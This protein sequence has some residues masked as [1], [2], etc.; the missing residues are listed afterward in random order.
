MEDQI[1]SVSAASSSEDIVSHN[2][3]A[4]TVSTSTAA[5]YVDP[6]SDSLSLTPHLACPEPVEVEHSGRDPADLQAAQGLAD[7]QMGQ[8]LNLSNNPPGSTSNP[9]TFMVNE[10]QEIPLEVRRSVGGKGLECVV[11]GKI[12]NRLLKLKQHHR[13]HTGERPWGCSN[14]G[15]TFSTASYLQK[16]RLT[17]HVP[18][19]Q[20]QFSCYVCHRGFGL[21]SSLQ[22]HLATHA[23]NKPFTC[24]I[25]GQSFALKFTLDTHKAQHTGS[26]PW[27]C[28]VCGRSYVTKYKLRA[29]MKAHTGELACSVCGRQFTSQDSM[30]RHQRLHEGSGK[31]PMLPTCHV[32]N[33]KFATPSLLKRHIASHERQN[34]LKC[35]VC[36][37][38]FINHQQLTAHQSQHQQSPLSTSHRCHVCNKLFVQEAHLSRHLATHTHSTF[39]QQN[40]NQSLPATQSKDSS[41][42]TTGSQMNQGLVTL[43]Q[44]EA[45]CF[46]SEKKPSLFQQAQSSSQMS[47]NLNQQACGSDG[48]LSGISSPQQHAHHLQNTQQLHTVTV[49]QSQHQEHLISTRT[50]NTSRSSS[51][52]PQVFLSA[53]SYDPEILG[54]SLQEA[55]YQQPQGQE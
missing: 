4:A 5:V 52:Q 20:R 46:I 48:Y 39:H 6:P 9:M 25:C 36:G 11:C 43:R 54:A 34:S 37:Q 41:R 8:N 35:N 40:S 12:F 42:D 29:H 31:N 18:S 50:G 3:E 27:V 53:V 2:N 44:S 14:C 32:C 26:R 17:C 38:D 1:G 21:R 13:T 24:D 22:T 30:G 23:S 47:T 28:S 33:K 10:L 7:L 19:H 45:A 15:K 49:E 55:A 16:H 51:L